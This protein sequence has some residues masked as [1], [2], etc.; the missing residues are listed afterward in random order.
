[1]PSRPAVALFAGATGGHARA[2]FQRRDDG[3][4]QRRRARLVGGLV[5]RREHAPA[6]GQHQVLLAAAAHVV[7][8]DEVRRAAAVRDARELLVELGVGVLPHPQQ[9]RANLQIALRI[10]RLRCAHSSRS[11]GG[12]GAPSLM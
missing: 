4:T 1:M 6:R 5:I 10:R 11:T 7:T 3:Q 12:R 9:A 8:P 2:T